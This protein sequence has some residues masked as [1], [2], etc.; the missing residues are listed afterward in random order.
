M[1]KHYQTCG[2]CIA[3]Y[4][5]Q[6]RQGGKMAERLSAESLRAL[7]VASRRTIQQLLED[8]GYTAK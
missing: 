5:T 3:A 2:A 1:N 4:Q 6:K 8:T 7:A